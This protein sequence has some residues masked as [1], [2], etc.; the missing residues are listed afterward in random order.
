MLVPFLLIFLGSCLHFYLLQNFRNNPFP[1]EM[2][3][4]SPLLL[5]FA[6]SHLFHRKLRSNKLVAFTQ[7]NP[8]VSCKTWIYVLQ[9]ISFC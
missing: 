2:P 7:Q 4:I 9:K 5:S 1:I 3:A 6:Q 8:L